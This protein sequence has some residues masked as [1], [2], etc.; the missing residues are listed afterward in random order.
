MVAC[1][2][3]WHDEALDPLVSVLSQVGRFSC[4]AMFT[5]ELRKVLPVPVDFV[6]F[7]GHALG[8]LASSKLVKEEVQNGGVFEFLFEMCMKAE[9]PEHLKNE[10]FRLLALGSIG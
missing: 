9:E 2:E 8:P 7:V 10:A 4:A 1:H 3:R 5:V 6:R